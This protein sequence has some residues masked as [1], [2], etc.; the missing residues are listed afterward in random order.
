MIWALVA[1]IVLL[2]LLLISTAAEA[3]CQRRDRL[4]VVAA[5]QKWARDRGHD[6]CWLSDHELVAAV[7]PTEGDHMHALPP[8]EEFLRECSKYHDGRAGCPRCTTSRL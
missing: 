8:R 6:R 4:A 3:Y 7:C 1:A 2:V 5:V